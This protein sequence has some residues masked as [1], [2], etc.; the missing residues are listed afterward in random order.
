ADWAG[1]GEALLLPWE[2]RS[3]TRTG[4]TSIL[5]QSVKLP[6]VQ[7]ILTRTIRIVDSEN[8]IYVHSEL[9]NQMGFDRP[10]NWAEHATIGS[11][12]LEAGIN[13]VGVS[14]GPSKKRKYE[15]EED[16]LPHRLSS[17]EEFTW[18]LGPAGCG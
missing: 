12:F 4:G 5:I 15:G 2:T 6:I 17:F 9:E 11:P 10:I 3:H 14:S 1:H 16:G 18:P 8:A 13:V 7:E